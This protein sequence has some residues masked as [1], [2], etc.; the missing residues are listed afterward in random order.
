MRGKSTQEVNEILD[1][2]L[3]AYF[4]PDQSMAAIKQDIMLKLMIDMSNKLESGKALQVV[5]AS[6]APA[7]HIEEVKA[8]EEINVVYADEDAE[9]GES[10]DFLDFLNFITK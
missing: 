6:P 7:I 8:I 4:N 3:N 10:E 1:K 5:S 9:N 2:A